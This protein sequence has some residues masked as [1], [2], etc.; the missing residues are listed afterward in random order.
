MFHT[1]RKHWRVD[2][3]EVRIE[4]LLVA[5]AARMTRWAVGGR[6]S[7]TFVFFFTLCCARTTWWSASKFSNIVAMTLKT[8]ARPMWSCGA[9]LDG[10]GRLI[11]DH[12][13]NQTHEHLYV[14]I[15]NGAAMTHGDFTPMAWR[16]ANKLF[17]SYTMVANVSEVSLLFFSV[18]FFISSSASSPSLLLLLSSSQTNLLFYWAATSNH[19][20]CCLYYLHE[21]ILVDYKYNC[22]RSLFWSSIS[23]RLA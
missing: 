6:R 22:F 4:V 23:Y 13:G 12:R 8:A 14:Q 7:H 1:F 17:Q 20:T 15:D 9:V 19:I 2:G 10:T 5:L 18:F 3:G 16:K 21:F 11:S